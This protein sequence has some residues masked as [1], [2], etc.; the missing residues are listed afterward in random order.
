VLQVARGHY[1]PHAYHDFIGFEVSKP[2][3]ERAFRDTYSLELKDVFGDLDL[4]LGTYRRTVSSIIPEM[5]KVAW[6]MEE[7]ELSKTGVTRKQF[8]YNISRGQFHKDWDGKFR[9]PGCGAR[10]LALFI[11]ILPKVG[12]LKS[13]KFKPP[14][15][16]TEKLFEE[17]FNKTLERYAGLL[18]EQRAGHLQLVN[19][20]F[21]TGKPTRPTEY[22]LADD[23][24][25]KLAIKL[26]DHDPASID[27]ALRRQILAYFSDLDVPFATRRKPKKWAKT[28]EAVAKL[29]A[30]PVAA[31]R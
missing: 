13:L 1:A 4:A 16:Q 24:F 20:D 2:V 22:R 14:T 9:E 17:S 26:A 23:A 31:T 5:T 11:R 29:R 8:I 10:V 28:V 27:P 3:L 12:P 25:S 6:K 18:N 21:D 15:P 19:C 7:D 30:M